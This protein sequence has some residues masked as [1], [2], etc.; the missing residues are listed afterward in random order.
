M[1]VSCPECELQVSDKAVA[2]PHCGY[3]FRKRST[4]S[5]SHKRVRSKLPN[6]FGQISKIRNQ[7]LRNPFRAMVTVGVTPEGRPISKIL[8]PQGYFHTYNEAYRAIME[9]HNKPFDLSQSATMEQIYDMWKKDKTGRVAP[10]TIQEYESAWK[11]CS[12]IYTMPIQDVHVRDL[13]TC[14]EQGSVTIGAETHTTSFNIRRKMK[15]L[16]NQ[17]FDYAVE[18]EITSRNVSRMFRLH[19][20]ARPEV[21]S[22]IPYSDAE[23]S[24]LAEN[25]LEHPIIEMIQIQL[26]SGWRPGE[27][28]DLLVANVDLEKK[29]FTGGKKTRNGIN[30]TIPIH[31]KI[32]PL[33]EKHYHHAI[34][35]GSKYLFCTDRKK[36]HHITYDMFQIRY[37][38]LI[39]SLSLDSH[40]RPHDG[41]VHF[42]TAA[43]K[44][45]M[46]EYAIKIIVGHTITDLTE[47]VYTKRDIE[48]LRTELEKIP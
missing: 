15:I 28:C 47:R 9:Y 4:A 41:R 38:A 6:G 18:N 20:E 1:L 39:D 13:K 42:V 17:L 2:C 5:P 37:R 29:C 45:K 19:E 44:A 11:Y 24:I 27:L 7:K 23:V 34:A 35:S 43:K 16:F 14:L 10:T 25:I 12:L 3:P 36:S 46:D 22:H 33:V 48:W 8:R 32:F 30:R 31:S 26:Y 21:R 40:H